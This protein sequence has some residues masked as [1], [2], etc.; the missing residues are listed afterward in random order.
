MSSREKSIMANPW[1]YNAVPRWRHML[2]RV[3]GHRV[4][5]YVS[6]GPSSVCLCCGRCGAWFDTKR[7]DEARDAQS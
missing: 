1:G 3:V 2:C 4:A 5:F 6:S 7:W